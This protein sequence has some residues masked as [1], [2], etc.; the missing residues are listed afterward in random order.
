MQYSEFKTSYST[1]VDDLQTRFI[2]ILDNLDDQNVYAVSS[3]N[4]QRITSELNDI[5][6]KLTKIKNDILEDPK[7]KININTINNE[8]IQY[9]K[10][11]LILKNR[12]SKLKESHNTSN[13]MI[14]DY[15]TIYN[16]YYLKNAAILLGILMQVW[17]LIKVFKSN[18]VA[19][20][21]TV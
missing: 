6:A 2:N 17:I 16:M 10:D 5:I 14:D 15:V 19:K 12:V 20:V 9:K 1:Q 4:R 21:P 18:S 7:T 13:I 3:G 11:Y 8:V